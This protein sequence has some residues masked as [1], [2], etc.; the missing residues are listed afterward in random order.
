MTT[1]AGVGALPMLGLLILGTTLVTAMLQSRNRL[2]FTPSER[3]YIGVSVGAVFLVASFLVDSTWETI[4]ILCVGCFA[5]G[6][7]YEVGQ[8]SEER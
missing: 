2:P 6:A 5:W 4:V 1:L 8:I 7:G 3:A